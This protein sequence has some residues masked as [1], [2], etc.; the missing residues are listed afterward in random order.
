MCI[1]DSKRGAKVIVIDPWLS[2]TSQMVADEWIP[3][4]PGS[5]TALVIAICYEWINAGT[6]DQEFLDT[7]CIG[8]EMCIRDRENRVEEALIGG[9]GE[10]RGAYRGCKR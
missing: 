7:Y 3:I 10:T 2:Q 5:D 1:R 9:E 6:Y 4:L 8:F